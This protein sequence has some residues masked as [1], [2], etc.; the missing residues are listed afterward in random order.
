MAGGALRLRAGER[1]RVGW[2]WGAIL[3]G[4]PHLAAREKS[5]EEEVGRAGFVG[6]KRRWAR[7]EKEREGGELL[8]WAERRGRE[9]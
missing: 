5:G 7:G 1:K 3:T 8:G 4:G 2:R 6:R 9:V